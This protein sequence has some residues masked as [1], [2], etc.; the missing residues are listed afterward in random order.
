M[1]KNLPTEPA[2]G[3]H[4]TVGSGVKSRQ[5]LPLTVIVQASA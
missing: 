2:V 5:I 3:P 1:I 4:L